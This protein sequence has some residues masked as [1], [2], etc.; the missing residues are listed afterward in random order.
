[1]STIEEVRAAEKKVQE[2]LN[3]LNKVDAQDCNHLGAELKYGHGRV[4]K[5]GSR[6]GFK[7]SHSVVQGSV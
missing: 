5:N 7:L 1:M 6:T 3:A 2:V 4:R